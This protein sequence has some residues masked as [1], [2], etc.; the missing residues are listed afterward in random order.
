MFFEEIA[1]RIDEGSPV[2]IIYLDFQKVDKAPHQR[3]LHKLWY[4]VW[5]N[6]LDRTMADTIIYVVIFD[7]AN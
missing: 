2:D 5:Q 3:L 1:K 4:R 6:L 7:V